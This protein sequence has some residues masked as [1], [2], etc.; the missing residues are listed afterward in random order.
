M[1][2]QSLRMIAACIAA[3]TLLPLSVQA[4][5]HLITKYKFDLPPSADL[6]YAVKAQQSGLMLDGNATVTWR[7]SDHKFTVTTE[8]RAMLAGKVLEDS[9]EGIID[10]YGLAPITFTEKRFRK[11]ATTTS[12][13]RTNKVIHFSAS[14]LTYPLRGGE[15]DRNSAIWQLISVARAA[16]ARFRP[17]SEWTF[18]VAGQRD[19]DPWTF[20]VIKQEQITTPMGNMNTFHILKT[21]SG[22]SNHQKVDIWL[23]PSLEWF[24]V[25]LR[26]T[27]PD[28]DF[29]EQSITSI[30][31]K[32]A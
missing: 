25:R 29:I 31:K 30:D 23:A 9:S 15:Q 21:T 19:A 28:S 8:V 20:K 22:G 12:F 2:A 18:F 17:S 27:D 1:V 26:Y 5:N 4:Q 16:P 7:A 24:P 10:A 6:H 11:D 13:D 32:P 3:C 14:D